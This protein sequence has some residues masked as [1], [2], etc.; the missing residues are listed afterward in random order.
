MKGWREVHGKKGVK[1]RRD[2]DLNERLEAS[3]GEGG[4]M[5][6]AGLQRRRT[7]EPPMRAADGLGLTAFSVGVFRPRVSSYRN[8]FLPDNHVYHV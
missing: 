8:L 2:L 4:S 5:A 1:G 7:R 6:S 3:A